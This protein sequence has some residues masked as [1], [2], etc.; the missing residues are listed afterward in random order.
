MIIAAPAIILS[1]VLGWNIVVTI[2]AIGVPTIVYTM[3][4]G[5]QAVTWTDVKQ[6]AVVLFAMASAVVVLIL[7]L[8]HGMSVGDALHVAG[9]LGKLHAIDFRFDVHEKYTIWSGLIG[10]AVPVA[11][12]L[13]LRP[14]P[15]AAVSDGEVARRR[16]GSRCC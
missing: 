10:G 15:G 11:V 9:S 8:P 12:V 1:I 3:F 6:M 14:E 16:A 13:R 5:V 2:L 7:G 4:G